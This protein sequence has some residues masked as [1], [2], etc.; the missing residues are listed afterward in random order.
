ME[1]L[2][3][4]KEA[5]GASRKAIAFG[6]VALLLAA[7]FGWLIAHIGSGG[8]ESQPVVVA[9]QSIDALVPLKADQLKVIQWPIAALPEGTFTNIEDVIGSKLDDVKHIYISSLVTNEPVFKSKVSD[10][11][12][13]LGVS[14][15]V[16]PNMRAFVVQVEE[17]AGRAQIVHPGSMV[18]V[19]ATVPD[20]KTHLA[21]TRV[22]L[23][24]IKVLAVGDR[25]DI[26]RQ[27]TDAD[28]SA[29]EH[30]Q[31][32]GRRVVTLLVSLADAEN[33]ALASGL[34]RLDLA[35][36]SDADSLKVKTPGA[37]LVHM[38]ASGRSEAASD[39]AAAQEQVAPPVEPLRPRGRPARSRP[40]GGTPPGG[41]VIYKVH[42]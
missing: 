38:L 21:L 6:L 20:P 16:E 27:P 31:A 8:P 17:S 9:G 1:L 32:E 29:F 15:F 11:A 24:N 22:I 34:G 12:R 4:Q 37:D 30:A 42:H 41:P 10:P 2:E 40:P 33:L 7:A 36:R 13:G 19:I 14:Q 5:D 39:E 35:L 26:P 3:V 25:V 28:R 23:Q 18:D